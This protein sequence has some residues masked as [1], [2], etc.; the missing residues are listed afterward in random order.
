MNPESPIW[1]ELNQQAGDRL[2][3]DFSRRVLA[4]VG[5]VRQ[6]RRQLAAM[7]TTL[8]LCLFFTTFTATWVAYRQ[9]EQ[10]LT[11]WRALASVTLAIDRGL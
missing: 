5:V 8:A 6:Q 4:Q 7:G 9:H 10:N 2:P 3:E 1:N 11:Q